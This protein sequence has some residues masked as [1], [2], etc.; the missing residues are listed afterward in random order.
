MPWGDPSRLHSRPGVP[1]PHGP[2]ASMAAHKNSWTELGTL[3]PSCV[4]LCPVSQS[5][6][7]RSGKRPPA[8]LFL[9]CRPSL[10][11]PSFPCLPCASPLPVASPIFHASAS[12]SAHGPSSHSFPHSQTDKESLLGRVLH[13]KTPFGLV[14]AR[15]LEAWPPDHPAKL[16]SK[17]TDLHQSSRMGRGRIADL[18]CNLSRR[19]PEFFPFAFFSGGNG[20]K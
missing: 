7:V 19:V 10:R 1:H 8:Q 4:A 9:D 2:V 20:M 5:A 6:P 13:V 17:A 18:D 11:L 15:S 16:Q 3:N 14:C 12:A